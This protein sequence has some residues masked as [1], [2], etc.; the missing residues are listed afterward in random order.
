MERPPPP[1]VSSLGPNN[2]RSIIEG[3][4]TSRRVP[5]RAHEPGEDVIRD[6]SRGKTVTGDSPVG[7]NPKARNVVEMPMPKTKRPRRHVTSFTSVDGNEYSF[8]THDTKGK[9]LPFREVQALYLAIIE[10]A[11]G[12]SPVPVLDAFKLTMED[13]GGHVVYPIPSHL[14]S[15]AFTAAA[16]PPAEAEEDVP[17]DRGFSLGG[18]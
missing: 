10:M 1:G 12:G 15:R 6:L 9:P 18:E 8:R 11:K 17:E 3:A 2:Q 16:Q 14:L 13:M 4:P 5:G 7:A